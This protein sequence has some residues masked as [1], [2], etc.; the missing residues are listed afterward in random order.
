MG[1]AAVVTA[2]YLATQAAE[3]ILKQGGNAVEAAIAANAVLG[4]VA[5]ETCG[6]GGDLFAIVHVPGE[7]VPH[8]LNSSGWA[9]SNVDAPKLRET[10]GEIPFFGKDAVTVPGCV[11]GWYEL[12]ER[13]ASFSMNELLEAAIAH[14]VNGFEVSDEL[15]QALA[16]RGSEIQGQPIAAELLPGGHAPALGSVLSRPSLGATLAS[17]AKEGP[18]AFYKGQPALDICEAVDQRIVPADLADFAPEWVV[19]LQ[20]QLFGH[21]GWTIPPNSQGISDTRDP[22][23]SGGTGSAGGPNRPLAPRDRGLPSGCMG[24]Q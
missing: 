4:V 16:S 19:P 15:A 17:I 24:T 14:A 7:S 22:S 9:G 10:H 11:A 23:H 18:D 20:A 2:H 12:Q 5:P 6:V 21:T 13:F 8:A 1:R 3:E